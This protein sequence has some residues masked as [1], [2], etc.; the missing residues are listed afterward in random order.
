[1][2]VLRAIRRSTGK[3][4]VELAT[5]LKSHQS[6]ISDFENGETD[7]GLSTVTNY[8]AKLGFRLIPIETPYPS[9]AEAALAFTDAIKNNDVEKAHVLFRELN[10]NLKKSSATTLSALCSTKP[11][12]GGDRKFDALIAA[13]VEY[14]LREKKVPLPHWISETNLRLSRHWVYNE[15]ARDDKKIKVQ[16]PRPFLKKNIYLAESELQSI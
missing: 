16:T 13:L 4:Q 11:S 14:R 7:P 6:N 1:M 15:Y 3:T 5:L 8:L 9:V 2:S 10:E 12:G